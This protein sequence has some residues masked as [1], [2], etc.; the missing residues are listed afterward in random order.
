MLS[1]IGRIPLAVVVLFLF[2]DLK[3]KRL[4]DYGSF[5]VVSY[6]DYDD[7]VGDS[8][9]KELVLDKKLVTGILRGMNYIR[10]GMWLCDGRERRVGG[11]FVDNTETTVDE[12]RKFLFI[13]TDFL[14]QKKKNELSLL[15]RE[16]LE[17]VYGSGDKVDK[18]LD[19]QDFL[20]N[21]LSDEYVEWLKPLNNVFSEELDGDI[22][23]KFG[24]ND[25][26]TD[27]KFGGYPIVGL[28]FEQ[29]KHFLKWRTYYLIRYLVNQGIET[30]GE[31]EFLTFPEY[32][33]IASSGDRNN[34]YAWGSLNV[35][36]DD[37]QLFANFNFEN[38][39]MCGVNKYPANNFGV[40]DMCGNVDEI[41][42]DS[43]NNNNML[44]TTAVGNYA[45]LLSDV[46][47]GVSHFEHVDRARHCLSF[48]A[49]L[50]LK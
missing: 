12:Y 20:T 46:R 11:F 6:S 32:C 1:R 27:P 17:E 33:Y 18:V 5:K 24:L 29:M 9:Q 13:V 8:G 49:K 34:R 41:T 35:R 37:G 40:R 42:S 2:L 50:V 36:S 22:V 48:R 39:F 26:F 28:I 23:S 16:D 15:K 38:E 21:S 19:L 10:E 43:A 7:V 31:Y 25:Y 4:N 45:S 47:I 44:K 3:A 30:Y 14:D